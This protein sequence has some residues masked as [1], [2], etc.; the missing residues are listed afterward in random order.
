[1]GHSRT[2]FDLFVFSL[3]LTVKKV[4]YKS[5]SMMDL[6]RGPLVSEATTLPTERQPLPKCLG[7][8]C[9]CALTYL[10]ETQNLWCNKN[11]GI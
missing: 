11:N 7:S 3:Q 9:S 10:G 2:L 1:M 5:L 8:V 6:N 4:L